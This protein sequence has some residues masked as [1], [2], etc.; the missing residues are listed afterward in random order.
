[1][2]SGTI[3]LAITFIILLCVVVGLLISLELSARRKEREAKKKRKADHSKTEL[4]KAPLSKAQDLSKTGLS[5]TGLSKTGLSKTG[6]S[7]APKLDI[8]NH[9]QY[10]S[11][12]TILESSGAPL[13]TELIDVRTEDDKPWPVYFNYYQNHGF[14]TPVRD[15]KQCGSCWAF[16]TTSMIADRISIATQGK[17]KKLLSVQYMTS[18]FKGGNLQGCLGGMPDTAIAMMARQGVPLDTT[19]PYQQN[20]QSENASCDTGGAT[21]PCKPTAV[22]GCLIKTQPGSLYKVCDTDGYTNLNTWNKISATTIKKNVVRM[23]HEIMRY[24]PIVATLIVYED[25]YDYRP[26]EVYQNNPNSN[27]VG[28]HAMVIVGWQDT[29]PGVPVPYWICK[30]SY[31]VDFGDEGYMNIRMGTNECLIESNCSGGFPDLTASC[32]TSSLP[33]GSTDFVGLMDA[34]S[35]VWLASHNVQ[36]ESTML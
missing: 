1:M 16:S 3:L 24:G 11:N 19:Y 2:G 31:S 20:R 34:A 6:L 35:K 28:G 12:S 21:C 26:G 10:R 5:K 22:T 25:F 30:N 36:W 15:Q 32:L 7:K 4:S 13:K 29:A 9:P 23:K 27:Y 8:R 33:H 18:C 17:F 14:L